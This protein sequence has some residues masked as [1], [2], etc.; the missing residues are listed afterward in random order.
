[1]ARSGYTDQGAGGGSV[2]LGGGISVG[3]QLAYGDPNSV[4]EEIPDA[5]GNPLPQL[6]RSP[7]PQSADLPKLVNNSSG[8]D[9]DEDHLEGGLEWYPDDATPLEL[10]VKFSA[11][12]E[13]AS[14]SVGIEGEGYKSAMGNLLYLTSGTRPDLA[15]ALNSLCR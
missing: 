13:S 4:D 9:E 12:C 2:G 15:A 8:G 10:G 5:V 7:L 6:P 11:N 3:G 1:M 14:E